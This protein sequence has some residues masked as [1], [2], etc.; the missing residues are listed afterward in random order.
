MVA[1][2]FPIA[3]GWWLRELL[4]ALLRPMFCRWREAEWAGNHARAALC[5]RRFLRILNAADC[6]PFAV[7][8]D[9]GLWILDAAE[10]EQLDRRD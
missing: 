7:I 4:N 6:D 1:V 10:A 5:E 3:L 2:L 8:V 9:Q